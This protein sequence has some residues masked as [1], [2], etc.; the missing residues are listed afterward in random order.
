MSKAKS[1]RLKKISPNACRKGFLRLI[2]IFPGVRNSEV[3]PNLIDPFGFDEIDRS[4]EI[5]RPSSVRDPFPKTGSEW[6]K[7][8]ELWNDAT[9]R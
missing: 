3:I 2:C 9:T 6:K 7:R 1:V 8:K 4:K 5:E